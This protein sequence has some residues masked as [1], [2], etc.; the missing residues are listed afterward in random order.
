MPGLCAV[1][2]E[3]RPA[4]NKAE[5]LWRGRKRGCEDN[6]RRVTMLRHYA[7]GLL[8]TIADVQKDMTDHHNGSGFRWSW[9]AS[10]A[11]SDNFRLAWAMPIGSTA[12][13]V[14]A[15]S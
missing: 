1:I 15:T 6:K 12:R 10:G 7:V 8:E 3:A 14:L 9:I 4:E 2:Y 5:S 11:V 13:S